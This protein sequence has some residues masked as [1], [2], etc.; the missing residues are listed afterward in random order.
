MKTLYM[1]QTLLVWLTVVLVWLAMPG[2]CAGADAVASEQAWDGTTPR[3]QGRNID[4]VTGE[5]TWMSVDVSPN[6]LEAIHLKISVTWLIFDTSCWAP[7]F[8]MAQRV[9]TYGRCNGC[10]ARGHWGPAKNFMSD[11]RDA[12]GAYH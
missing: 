6:N 10:V 8:I 9:I 7:D 5:G 11:V 4:F 12:S 3:G 2:L 1:M